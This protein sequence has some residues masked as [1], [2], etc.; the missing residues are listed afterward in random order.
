MN[1]A[2]TIGNLLTSIPDFLI[3]ASH[4]S[5]TAPSTPPPV[6]TVRGVPLSAQDMQTLRNVLFA[7]I[8][9]R[10]PDKQSLEARTIINT[11]L[12]RI[13]Q[14]GAQGKNMSLSQVLSA[15]NQYQG[16]GSPEYQRITNNATTTTDAQKL[17]AIDSTLSQ[18]KTGNFPDTTAGSVYYH[19]N[20]QGQIFTRPGT[21]YKSSSAAPTMASLQ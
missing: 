4:V 15:P 14:Y 16:Y 10:T 12:N 2:R 21:L 1:P 13:P 11:A 3:P 7:E 17:G 20:D 18:L 8:S 6:A 19:H 9:N 5:Y